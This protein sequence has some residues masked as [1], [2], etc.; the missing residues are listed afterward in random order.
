MNG[1]E[2]ALRV[3]RIRYWR[4]GGIFMVRAGLASPEAGQ[5]KVLVG[6][7]VILM[8]GKGN[9]RPLGIPRMFARAVIKNFGVVVVVLLVFLASGGFHWIQR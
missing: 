8:D 6:L 7:H 9:Q 1:T 3:A 4:D 5:S 2:P